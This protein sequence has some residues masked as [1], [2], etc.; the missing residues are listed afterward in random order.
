MSPHVPLRHLALVPASSY[1]GDMK[2]DMRRLST[3]NLLDLLKHSI[4]PA[5]TLYY[6]F[7]DPSP[8]KEEQP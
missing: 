1:G 2:G 7:Q 8:P 5:H 3:R 6:L 4:S